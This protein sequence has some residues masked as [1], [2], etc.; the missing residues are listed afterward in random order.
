MTTICSRVLLMLLLASSV[1]CGESSVERVTLPKDLREIS[2]LAVVG[3]ALLAVADE[4]SRIY[5]ISF[6]D[7]LVEYV[8]ALGDPALKGDFEGIAVAGENILLITS[9]GQLY[10]RGLDAEDQAY[11]VFD[12]GFGE[13]CEIEGLEY[14]QGVAYVLCKTARHDSVAERLTVLA[15]DLQR[16]QPRPELGFSVP[17]SE[18]PIGKK[19]HP[20]ALT[21]VEGEWLVLAAR[22][23]RWLVLDAQ[24]EYLRGGKLPN[25][26]THPQAE[27][28]AVL[29]QQT[30]IADEGNK[31]G[32]LTRYQGLF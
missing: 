4:K 15:W 3:N 25:R 17:W 21:W 6:A 20:S 13:L 32:T 29:G 26:N 18:L 2:G 27:G 14:R 24:G 28:V 5:R 12:T 30:F 23:Q 1:A 9:D 7:G 8:G 16:K 31:R 10:Q 11:D 22:Q 19:L